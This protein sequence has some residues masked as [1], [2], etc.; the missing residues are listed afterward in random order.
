MLEEIY[1][2]ASV[3]ATRL[4]IHTQLS[5]IMETMAKSTLSQLCKLVDEESAELRL[6]CSRLLFANSALT[7]K[8]NS[9]QCELTIVKTNA[10]KSCKSYR[11]VGVQTVCS[12]EEDG[13]V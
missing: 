10:S 6:E 8:V 5:S 1:H 12:K 2:S 4:S 7:E 13:M 9:L 3:M 11:T